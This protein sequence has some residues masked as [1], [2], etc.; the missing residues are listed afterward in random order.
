[1]LAFPSTPEAR[2]LENS[3]I[4]SVKAAAEFGLTKNQKLAALLL[5]IQDV[6]ALG[7]PTAVTVHGEDA[8]FA[9][10]MADICILTSSEF[11][12]TARENGGFGTD[13]GTSEAADDGLDTI[14]PTGIFAGRWVRIISNSGRV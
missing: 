10:R 12:R 1:M 7:L 11:G 13:H 2:L 6:H 9:Q 4:S 8:D 5:W 3:A 14:A